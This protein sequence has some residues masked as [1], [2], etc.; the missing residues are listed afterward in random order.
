MGI[1]SGGGGTFN[2]GTITQ[3]LTIDASDLRLDGGA[4]TARL[5]VTSTPFQQVY[6]E[7]EASGWDSENG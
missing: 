6:G 4:G 7:S 1:V 2:G 3:P 5:R